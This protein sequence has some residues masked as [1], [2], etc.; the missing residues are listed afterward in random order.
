MGVAGELF[1]HALLTLAR[2]V[3]ALIQA[4]VSRTFGAFTDFDAVQ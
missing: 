4:L 2:D 3:L 1:D